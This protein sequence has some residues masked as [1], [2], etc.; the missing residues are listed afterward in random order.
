MKINMSMH[1][2]VSVM[3]HEYIELFKALGDAT[4]QDILE[5]L[6]DH[7]RNV[8][9]LCEAC[10]NITQPTIS[11]HLQILR[12]CNLVVRRRKGKMIYYSINKKVLRNGFEV[13]IERL[14]IQ[15]L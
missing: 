13:F 14:N 1:E 2:A 9:E 3:R 12:H 4:R 8:N 11:H 5:L 15:I 6:E 10:E 7:E